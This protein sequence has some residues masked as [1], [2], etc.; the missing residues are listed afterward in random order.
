[1]ISI[2]LFWAMV[3]SLSA[4]TVLHLWEWAI[5]CNCQA[6]SNC[7]INW[8]RARERSFIFS[9]AILIVLLLS[10][11]GPTMMTISLFHAV[12]VALIGLTVMHVW[13]FIVL[14]NRPNGTQAD[15]VRARERSLF[16]NL[17]IMILLL[18]SKMPV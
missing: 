8:A 17:A 15:W 9:T 10:E 2:S 18:I 12:L 5:W 16:L 6:G 4:V 13:E 7:K 14:F 3:V 1:M 11:V